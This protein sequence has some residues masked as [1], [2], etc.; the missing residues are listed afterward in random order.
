MKALIRKH[1]STPTTE[2]Q[3]EIFPESSWPDWVDEK[4]WPL[5][6]ENYG[7]AL[8]QECPEDLRDL[9]ADDFAVRSET[10][11]K[12]DE[13]GKQHERTRWIAVFVGDGNTPANAS[14]T[15]IATANWVIARINEMASK[16]GLIGL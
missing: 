3:D 14:G 10:Y 16:N 9:A 2:A 1:G 5:T 4:G 7:Y 11:V 6:D 15:E 12:P 8:C 13:Y